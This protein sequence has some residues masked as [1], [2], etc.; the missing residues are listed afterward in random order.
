MLPNFVVIGA[1]KSG[2]SS[3]YSYLNSHP[4]VFMSTPKEPQYFA[5]E[6]NWSL[7]Q[8]W[9]ESLFRDAGEATA[10]G[11][12]STV[13]TKHPVHHGVPERMARLIPEARLIYLLRHPVERIRSHYE[14]L[15]R[16]G[17]ESRPLAVAVLEDPKFVNYSSY[18]FQI[19]QYLD[20][21]PRNQML[22]VTSEDLR[23]KRRATL[24]RVFEF[25]GID[26]TWAP[27][28][29]DVEHNSTR[30]LQGRSF[31]RK[32]KQLPG[33]RT[34]GRALPPR[35]KSV[36]WRIASKSTYVW[37]RR[38]SD[39]EVETSLRNLA[40]MPDGVR[41]ELESRLAHD[42]ARLRERLGSEF[43]GWGIK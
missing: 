9:Y 1:Q 17:S 35:A 28:Q 6:R 37:L 19:E 23:N 13:Y 31:A 7:G 25:L 38:D 5:T 3:L 40:S 14:H 22:V 24:R 27:P 21:F 20:W 39:L 2:T 12:A 34:I 29:M 43:D 36:Y 42:V 16:L 15:L 41:R 18:A 30:K 32:L 11:E 26:E 33:Y 8:E 10:V 4:Q